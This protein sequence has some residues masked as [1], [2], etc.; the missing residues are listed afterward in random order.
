[1][2]GKPALLSLR[3]APIVLVVVFK[4]AIASGAD[5]PSS[6]EVFLREAGRWNVTYMQWPQGTVVPA[7][8]PTQHFKGIETDT[9]SANDAT[10]RKKHACRE[11]EL[12]GPTLGGPEFQR[13]AFKWATGDGLTLSYDPV[14]ATY[15]AHWGKEDEK[16]LGSM[17]GHF[18]KKTK[19]LLLTYVDPKRPQN[20][21]LRHET[22]YIDEKTKRVTISIPTPGNAPLPTSWIMFVMV[23]T[24]KAD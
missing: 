14:T 23:A 1:M 8:E 24:K 12:A 10:L 7:G 11:L 15:S 4:F 6:N 13:Q 20:A 19:T 21:E 16:E 3:T 18:D 5:A 22:Q 2:R 9:V 17:K